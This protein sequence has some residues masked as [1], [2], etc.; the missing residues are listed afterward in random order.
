VLE[1]GLAYVCPDWLSNTLWDKAIDF[2]GAHGSPASV[3]ALY[4]RVL[5]CPIKELDK[6]HQG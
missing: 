2:E 4:A 6:Y 1:R 3:A 5:G